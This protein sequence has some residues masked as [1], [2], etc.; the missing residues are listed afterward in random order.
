MKLQI[1]SVRDNKA[2]AYGTPFF[3]KTHGEAERTFRQLAS[4]PQSMVYKY[5]SDF[6]LWHL[7][8]TN[9]TTGIINALAAPRHVLNAD[10]IPKP[11]PQELA[12]HLG[13]PERQ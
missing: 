7:G 11:I 4:D 10:V 1:Y 9:T 2:E 13:S 6:D 12:S 5:P 3:Q 8:E